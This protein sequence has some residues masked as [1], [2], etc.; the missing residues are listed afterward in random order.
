V[1]CCAAHVR[2]GGGASF[3][4]WGG[5]GRGVGWFGG[6]GGGGGGGVSF[7]LYRLHAELYLLLY[8]VLVQFSGRYMSLQDVKRPQV[9]MSEGG[10]ETL[11]LH[12]FFCQATSDIGCL[13]VTNHWRWTA[14]SLDGTGCS[15]V[16]CVCLHIVSATTAGHFAI[17][18]HRVCL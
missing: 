13:S 3:L 12:R 8:L 7:V 11:G 2:F 6:G 10:E 15:F 14:P 4:L 16:V 9:S 18:R 17:Q 1:G 5:G